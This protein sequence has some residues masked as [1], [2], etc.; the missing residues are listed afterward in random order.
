MAGEIRPLP[1]QSSAAALVR[2]DISALP[3]VAAHVAGR[4]AIIGAAMALFGERDPRRFVG[5]SLAGSFGIEC[6]VLAH[7][8]WTQR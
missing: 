7:E 1:S 6:F 2:G 3:I 4:A 5:G 8:L